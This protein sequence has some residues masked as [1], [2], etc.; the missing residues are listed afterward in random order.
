[1]QTAPTYDELN[2]SYSQY[3][4]DYLE[5]DRRI[6]ASRSDT[7][8]FV[9]VCSSA[10]FYKRQIEWSILTVAR[11]RRFIL[12]NRR[13]MLPDSI[14]A[15]VRFCLSWVIGHDCTSPKAWPTDK[16]HAWLFE[17]LGRFE[18]S[19]PDCVQPAVVK[20]LRRVA[21]CRM[22]S[23]RTLYQLPRVPPPVYFGYSPPRTLTDKEVDVVQKLAFLRFASTSRPYESPL[24]F[25]PIMW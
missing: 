3:W 1:M 25:H 22:S 23:F 19:S 4:L 2:A 16:F 6:F 13:C 8:A 20:S 12:V 11:Y 18:R 10:S 5:K 17:K 21:A 15:T 9:R 14:P 7:D 24:K